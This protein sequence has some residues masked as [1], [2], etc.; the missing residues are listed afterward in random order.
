MVLNDRDKLALIRILSSMV[1]IGLIEMDEFAL[2][3][4]GVEE[5]EISELN[6]SETFMDSLLERVSGSVGGPA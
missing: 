5:T 3:L 2:V 4:V 1:S 6:V